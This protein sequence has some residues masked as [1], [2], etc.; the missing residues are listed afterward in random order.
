MSSLT[1]NGGRPNWS[2]ILSIGINNIERFYASKYLDSQKQQAIDTLL[3]DGKQLSVVAVE[4]QP[5]ESQVFPPQLH[6]LEQQD[7]F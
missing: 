1:R 6:S 4:S 3:G 7:R 5:E 2:D